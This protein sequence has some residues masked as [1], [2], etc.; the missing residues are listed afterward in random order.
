[1]GFQILFIPG[2]FSLAELSLFFHLEDKVFLFLALLH[3]I[4][5]YTHRHGI[6]VCAVF[7]PILLVF[8]TVGRKIFSYLE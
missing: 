7:S 3:N 1:M 4:P 2:I 6:P 5:Q 8:C